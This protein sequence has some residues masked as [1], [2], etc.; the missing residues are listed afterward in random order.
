MRLAF[1]GFV[2]VANLGSPLSTGTALAH[3]VSVYHD[4]DADSSWL[5]GIIDTIDTSPDWDCGHHSYW[6]Y[7]ELSGPTGVQGYW[8]SG[9]SITVNLPLDD[10]EF[11]QY[12][13]LQLT[14]T[15]GGG[16]SG[17]TGADVSITTTWYGYPTGSS[18]GC[19]YESTACTSGTPTCDESPLLVSGAPQPCAQF[20]RARYLNATG[21]ITCMGLFSQGVNNENNRVC[22]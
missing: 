2:I 4:N 22:Y 10:G 3:A 14:C 1:I 7:G 21:R 17:G 15:C 18:M 5:Y 13:L 11:D 6:T 8:T 19:I 12:G 16:Y 20:R 9:F